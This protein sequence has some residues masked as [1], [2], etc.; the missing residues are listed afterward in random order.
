[1]NEKYISTLMVSGSLGVIFSSVFGEWNNDVLALIILMAIDFIT[2]IITA[3][4]F[5]KSSKSETGGL[6]SKAALK[7]IA[8]KV[9]EMML[10]AAAFQSEMLLHVDYLRIA[11]IW[12]L[13]GAEI[14]SIMENADDMDILPESVKKV[15]GRVTKTLNKDEKEENKDHDDQ[16]GH[17]Q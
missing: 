13:C 6:S 12:G 8:K 9:C 4:A 15:L 14:I 16:D 5:Q 7:G 11:V 2:G 3:A 1:M 17:D 10:V